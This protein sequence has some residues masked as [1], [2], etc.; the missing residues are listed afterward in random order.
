MK[1]KL[2]KT[3]ILLV[4]AALSLTSC[5]EKTITKEE[6]AS[7]ETKMA[8]HVSEDSFE[9]PKKLSVTSTIGDSTGSVDLSVNDKYFHTV[10][11]AK[12]NGITVDVE[13]W[14]Y[15]KDGKLYTVSNG[16]L[17]KVYTET[18]W[19]ESSPSYDFKAQS[20]TY[21]SGSYAD[22]SAFFA[23]SVTFSSE[24]Y[25][26]GGDGSLIIDASTS[27]KD[28][29]HFEFNNYLLTNEKT[30]ISGVT[31]ETK[32][33]IGSCNVSYPNLSDYKAQ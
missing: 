7:Q 27:D 32:I 20:T 23:L 5:G 6:A 12:T 8:Q 2:F 30:V 3:F 16:L 10:A 14:V 19:N 15:V 9:S 11:H 28:T 18:T 22:A 17:G 4:G 1:T 25:K 33:N 24:S 21:V 13:S 31:T 29:Y 26:S